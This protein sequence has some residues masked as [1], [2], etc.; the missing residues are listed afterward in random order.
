[1]K[2]IICILL[3]MFAA[4]NS[5][6]TKYK[7]II[8]QWQHKKIIFPQTLDTLDQDSAWQFML[9]HKYK[10]LTIIDT[11]SCTEC[12][13]K[14][15]EWSK[16]I[17]QMDSIKNTSFIFIIHAKDYSYINMIKKKNSFNYPLF[18]DYKNKVGELNMFSKEPRFQT[19]L[20]NQ[21]NEVILI[22]NPIDNKYL[23]NLY[24]QTIMNK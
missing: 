11:N 17:H 9:N 5:D 15:Y 3:V 1:M 8:S 20:L 7:N 14:L 18:Y 10:I 4:C 2:I 12:R 13:L 6:R 23:W 22:D 16:L 19:F 24:K 21:N